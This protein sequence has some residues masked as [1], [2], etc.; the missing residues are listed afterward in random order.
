LGQTNGNQLINEAEGVERTGVLQ[1]V[2]KESEIMNTLLDPEIDCIA[3][4]LGAYSKNSL[5]SLRVV[6]SHPKITGKD[7]SYE[8]KQ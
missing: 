4:Q 3:Q 1:F 5:D 6:N 7:G 8:Q 2:S